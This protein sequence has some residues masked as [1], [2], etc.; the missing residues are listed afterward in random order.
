MKLTLLT[1]ALNNVPD[2]VMALPK[3]AHDTWEHKNELQGGQ[4]SASCTITGKPA[5]LTEMW[6]NWA[7]MTIEE[8]HKGVS[9]WTGMITE[10]ELS[11]GNFRRSISINDMWNKVAI[12]YE[13]T[14][15]DTQTTSYASQQDSIDK[16]GTKETIET[17]TGE[18]VAQATAEQKR[19]DF[20]E[21]NAWPVRSPGRFVQP[22]GTL[23]IIVSGFVFT[24]NWYFASSGSGTGN[25]SSRLETVAEAG[26]YIDTVYVIDANTTTVE[27]SLDDNIRAWS[28]LE[29]LLETG[30]GTDH[31]RFYV[32]GLKGYYEVI[33][34]NPRYYIKNG[35]F[36]HTP[37]ATNPISIWEL[38]PGVYRDLDYP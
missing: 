27:K 29:E 11:V 4:W 26:D 25:L 21:S 36:Y 12:E 10:M 28:Y 32:R 35:V 16:Y 6:N 8:T 19:D 30:D 18:K 1:S 37:Q 7:G 23:K 33:D 5:E 38:Q 9:T 14:N 34:K 20:L 13:D 3:S 22:K 24:L 17:D 15:G 2:E 31:F